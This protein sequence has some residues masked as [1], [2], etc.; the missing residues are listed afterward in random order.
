MSG[1]LPEGLCARPCCKP[2][3]L[4]LSY[5]ARV[6]PM[7]RLEAILACLQLQARSVWP[8]AICGVSSGAQ[9]ALRC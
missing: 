3:K 6:W 8:L 5:C 1:V 2:R 4:L 7:L 9:P